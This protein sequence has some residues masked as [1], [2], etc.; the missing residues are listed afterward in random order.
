[1]TARPST[2]FLLLN[3][4]LNRSYVEKELAEFKDAGFGGICLFDMGARGDA[5]ST[6]PAGPAFMSPQSVADLAHVIGVAGRL[7]MDVSLAVTSSW[8]LG[9]SWVQPE[10]GS[11][12]LVTS[13]MEV[14]GPTDFDAVLPFPLAKQEFYRDV[15]VLAIP[16]AQR[17]PGY[18]FV[19]ELPVERQGEIDRV[20]LYNTNSEDPDKYGPNQLFAKEFSVSVST[21]GADT[22]SFKEVV[23][24]TLQPREGEQEF[25]FPKRAAKYIRLFIM[26]GYNPRFDRVEL[27]EFEAYTPAG[28]NVMLAH[29]ANQASDG[30]RLVRFSSELGSLNNWSA[31]NLNDGRKSGARGSWSSAEQP[32]LMVAD[33]RSVVD[34]TK[35]V[36]ASGRLRWKAPPGKWT[37]LRYIAVNTG[38]HLKVPSPKSDGLAT[39][40]LSAGAT[41]R[42]LEYVVSHLKTVLPSFQG[43]AL[44]NLYLPSYEVQGRIW[45][46]DFLD[47]F[48]KLR[49]YDLAPF[50][51][52]KRRHCRQR[53]RHYRRP[54]RFRQDW[55]SFW[56]TISITRRPKWHMK[57]VSEWSR[58]PAVRDRRSIAC[59]SMRSQPWAR[60]TSSG[61]SFGLIVPTS[62]PCG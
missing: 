45:T 40:H 12:T 25:R 15:A 11:M 50:A 44:K 37:I 4:Y 24:G 23:H 53:G 54:L 7:G 62:D 60:W 49:G 27:A 20:V 3:G 32:P 22:K 19:F 13:R 38:E 6:P 5:K 1:M 21:T 42:C 51:G 29:S 14:S 55:A 57:P 35:S 36:D 28:V 34:L 46:P 52:V 61:A 30:P 2:Y 48:R 16:N 41:R 59:R 26:N 56:S 10:D 47:Q 33:S 31:N 43:T 39:D 18:E 58:R 9:G 8:D 17:V